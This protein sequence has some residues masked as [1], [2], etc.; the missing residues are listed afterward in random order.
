MVLALLA[1]RPAR[2]APAVEG[3]PTPGV[4]PKWVDIL[5]HAVPK[6][7]ESHSSRAACN[8]AVSE[9]GSKPPLL[10]EFRESGGP[11]GS[12]T[13]SSGWGTSRIF[14][15]SLRT[16]FGPFVGGTGGV[17][18]FPFR[19]RRGAGSLLCPQRTACQIG[20]RSLGKENP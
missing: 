2:A 10:M 1:A 12:M 17:S 13:G 20:R 15:L 16:A 3:T 4:H 18:P 6:P 8:A 11:R 14:F 5:A 19:V 7:A 9:G